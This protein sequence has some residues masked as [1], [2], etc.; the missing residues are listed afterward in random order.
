VVAELAK[1]A[2]FESTCLKKVL[3][4]TGACHNIFSAYEIE[5]R[6]QASSHICF[7]PVT[8]VDSPLPALFVPFDIE[9]GAAAFHQNPAMHQGYARLRFRINWPETD[10]GAGLPAMRRAGGARSHRR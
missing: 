2:S 9:G 7:G 5:R 1:S 3:E 6:P 4:L 10:V 8:S